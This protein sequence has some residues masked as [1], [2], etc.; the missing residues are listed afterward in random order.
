[1]PE[2]K[3]VKDQRWG[4]MAVSTGV[5]PVDSKKMT[6]YLQENAVECAFSYVSACTLRVFIIHVYAT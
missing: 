2:E 3:L 1:M 6:E 5:I 4:Y